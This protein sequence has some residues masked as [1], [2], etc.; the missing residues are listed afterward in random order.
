MEPTKSQPETPTLP[1]TRHEM[2]IIGGNGDTKI[3]WNPDNPDEVTT[4]RESFD[5][6]RAKSY[7]AFTVNRKGDK[8]EQISSFDPEAEAMI[9]V[10]PLRGG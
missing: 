4:A 10:P 9:L 8:G 1:P 3:A 2:S 5:K 6:L 7:L